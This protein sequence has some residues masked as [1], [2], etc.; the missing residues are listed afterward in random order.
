M[1]GTTPAV[2]VRHYNFTMNYV[3]PKA[4]EVTGC[5]HCL[6]AESGGSIAVPN[7]DELDVIPL[8]NFWRITVKTEVAETI[9]GYV[10][11]K[12]MES[13]A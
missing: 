7:T 8:K 4:T 2:A 1:D 13:M 10:G 5:C 11:T 9:V 12:L 6:H 3:S